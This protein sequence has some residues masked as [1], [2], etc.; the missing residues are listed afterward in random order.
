MTQICLGFEVHQPL[1]ISGNFNQDYARDKSPEELFDVYFNNQWNRMIID[2]VAEKC[3]LPANEI[4]LEN[5]ERL[6]PRFKVAYSLSGVFIDQCERWRKDV[7]ESFQ[8]LAS[9]GRV[10]FLDQTY[11]HSLAG[12]YD[13]ERA[14]F[15]EQV[16]LHRERMRELF[17]QEPRVFENTE[18]IYNDSIAKCAEE[19][20]YEG[21]YCEGAERVLGWR[22]PNYVYRAKDAKIKVL[23]KNYRLSDDMAFRFSAGWWNE[24]P[25]TA[26]KYSS[27][28]AATPEQCVNLFMDYETF[29]EHHWR[30]TGI[31]EF[32]RWLPGEVLKYK[33]LSF[34]TPSELVERHEPVGEIAVGDF[35]TVSWADI[36]RDTGA[37]LSN[38]MQRTCYRALKGMEPFVKG[39][40]KDGKA[41]LK[42]W[43]YLQV[44]DHLYYMFTAG[45]APG[46]VHGYFSQQTP[47]EIFH[48]YAQI[49]S[50]FQEKVSLRCP[51]SLKAPAFLLRLLPP[52]RA[53]HYYI[54][55][56]YTGLSAHS[57]DEFHDTI[58]LAPS[59]SLEFHLRGGDFEL[60]L[61]HTVGDAKLAKRIGELKKYP[62]QPEGLRE[63]LLKRVDKRIAEIRK[64]R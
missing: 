3:Y 39:A 25:L 27:W 48:S 41:L 8:R 51:S 55:G 1:R 49:I 15:R 6:E 13:S 17:H 24:Y 35:D 62:I 60:W 11:Y 12:L 29:G 18:F 58:N 34:A 42:T 44:S 20:G 31:M 28:L 43:R 32:L 2:R 10:E 26:D 30:E 4:I 53:L 46:V 52:D 63:K 59:E 36:E 40:G 50:D 19:M 23:L 57:L 5:I 21:I 47:M 14:E 37:W 33:N 56:E 22:S 16:R 45:G 9:T 54:D 7:L 38:D 61:E 64:R